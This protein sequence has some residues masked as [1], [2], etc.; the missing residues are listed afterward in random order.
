MT[1]L[2]RGLKYVVLVSTNIILSLSNYELVLGLPRRPALGAL[3]RAR[4][5]APAGPRACGHRHANN[6][7]NS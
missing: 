6:I 7:S 3:G 1:N 2:T 4:R 5:G